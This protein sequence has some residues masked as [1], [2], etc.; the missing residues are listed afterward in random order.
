VSTYL[1]RLRGLIFCLALATSIAFPTAAAAQFG[2]QAGPEGF[3]VSAHGAHYDREP[4]PR[5]RIPG[6]TG[7]PLH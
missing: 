2:F 4:E 1:P 5:P 6:A 3:A 7:G